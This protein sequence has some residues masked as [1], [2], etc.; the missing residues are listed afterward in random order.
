MRA[1]CEQWRMPAGEG[2]VK[3]SAKLPP[4]RPDKR[5]RSV[6][7]PI[8]S[9]CLPCDGWVPPSYTLPCPHPAV[10]RVTHPLFPHFREEFCLRCAS[11]E[12]V[13][14]SHWDWPATIIPANQRV[15]RRR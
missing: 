8:T 13:V 10:V 12:V 11:N 9:V 7:P 3:T 5:K 15:V 14:V 1:A 4:R 6:S 2:E